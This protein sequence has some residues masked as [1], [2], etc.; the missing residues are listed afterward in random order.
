M[1]ERRVS[2]WVG[3]IVVFSIAA[4]ALMYGFLSRAL[5]TRRTYSFDVIFE[6]SQGIE[7]G[8]EVRMAGVRVGTVSAVSLTAGHKACVQLR[9]KR[10]VE[11]GHS[12]EISISRGLIVGDTVVQIMSA[13]KPYRI[14]KEGDTM[15]GVSTPRVGDILGQVSGVLDEMK[16]A[17]VSLSDLMKEPVIRTGFEQTIENINAASEHFSGLLRELEDAAVRNRGQIDETIAEIKGAATSMRE[18]LDEVRNTIAESVSEEELQEM[19]KALARAAKNLDEATASLETLVT[20]HDVQSDIKTTLSNVRE[21]SGEAKELT[22][23]L[24]EMATDVQKTTQSVGRIATESHFSVG[25]LSYLDQDRYRGD[26]DLW[27]AGSRKSYYRLGVW[28]AGEGN[29]AN[30]QIGTWLEPNLG[31]RYG[32]YASRLGLGVDYKS[33]EHGFS[34]SLDVFRPNNPESELRLMQPITDDLSL[35]FG[36]EDFLHKNDPVFGLL[37]RK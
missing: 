24:N 14:V 34:A 4:L 16:S 9:I 35:V 36:V 19:Q 12:F 8:A 21:A 7:P 2:I 17:A 37:Y 22:G 33:R 5:E 1:T 28:D 32:L 23:T 30:V 10:P 11:I 27:L 3:I 26:L 15:Y 6:D 20:E 31:L 13:P 25:F 18:V 29:R